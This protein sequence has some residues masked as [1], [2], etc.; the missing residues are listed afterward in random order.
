MPRHEGVERIRF[1][2]R[3]ADR[4]FCFYAYVYAVSGI[5]SANENPIEIELGSSSAAA[6][7]SDKHPENATRKRETASAIHQPHPLAPGSGPGRTTRVTHAYRSQQNDIMSA[8]TMSPTAV[9]VAKVRAGGD[10]ARAIARERDRALLGFRTLKREKDAAS[11]DTG[12]AS[13]RLARAT[14]AS[15]SIR[16]RS[17][18]TRSPRIPTFLRLRPARSAASR[19]TSSAPP[20]PSSAR[21]TA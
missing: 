7:L 12:A 21:A 15:R 8:V 19:A 1:Y 6:R 2:D 5:F 3:A 9:P 16:T 4:R 10:R 18:D 14:R 17:A 13:R 20:P 11:H